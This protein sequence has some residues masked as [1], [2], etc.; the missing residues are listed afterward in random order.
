MKKEE[1]H[2]VAPRLAALKSS[3]E[4]FKLPNT[5]LNDLEIEVLSSLIESKL[6]IAVGKKNPFKV[7]QNYFDTLDEAIYNK[8]STSIKSKNN[9]KVPENYFENFESNLL[10]K[11]KETKVETKPKVISFNRLV[12]NIAASIAVAASLALFF[13]F[14]PFN[15]SETITFDS[16]AITDIEAYIENDRLDLNAY[17]IAAVYNEVELTPKIISTSIDESELESFLRNQDIEALL[18]EE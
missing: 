5:G 9:L 1:L 3:H 13:I 2:S 14:N 7:N 16:L 15:K 11:L 6:T 8:L 12:I 18:Y 17:Q 4:G 10:K